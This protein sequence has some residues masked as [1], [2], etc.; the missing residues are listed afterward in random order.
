MLT[1]GR[2]ELETLAA[3][4]RVRTNAHASGREVAVAELDEA[5]LAQLGDV[6]RAVLMADLEDEVLDLIEELGV[7]LRALLTAGARDEI[8]RSDATELAAAAALMNVAQWDPGRM[9]MPNVPKRSRAKSDSGLDIV[10]VRIH[11][12][13]APA[14][15][16]TTG[17]LLRIAS[18]KHSVQ[19]STSDC[20]A[21]LRVSLGDRELTPAYLAIQLRALHGGLL[22]E[23]YSSDAANRVFLFTQELPAGDYLHLTGVAVI[24]SAAL[25]ETEVRI[26]GS[27]DTEVHWHSA[28]IVAIPAIASLQ[29]A[30][31]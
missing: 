4:C 25:P 8:T 9:H 2:V 15:S 16:L 17:D 12:H 5:T 7:P 27:L 30:C 1:H 13:G 24:D 18:V 6:Y 23:G 26:N 21:K 10:E 20:I 3:S 28:V 22:S 29:D 11:A 19:A 31:V 14:D